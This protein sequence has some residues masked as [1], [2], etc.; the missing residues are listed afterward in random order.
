[1]NRQS[2]CDTT[3]TLEDAVHESGT[4]GTII[5]SISEEMSFGDCSPTTDEV[6][7]VSSCNTNGSS[8]S[9]LQKPLNGNNHL[10]LCLPYVDWPQITLSFV[11]SLAIV[12]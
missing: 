7:C 8:H 12:K 3:G 10:F 4:V 1:M 9:E 5:D 6:D 2:Q 11:R